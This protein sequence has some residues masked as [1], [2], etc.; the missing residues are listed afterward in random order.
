MRP[1][2]EPPLGRLPWALTATGGPC[3]ELS[4]F[5]IQG[6][7]PSALWA[8]LARVQ[9]LDLSNN[10]ISGTIPESIFEMRSLLKL[11]LENN[12]LSGNIPDGIEN[13]PALAY[14]YAANA[15]AGALAHI[16]Y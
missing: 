2:L 5:G 11:N 15:P 3:S 8:G 14:M 12:R 13:A 1:S 16:T 9:G 7:L 6:P 4:G 10:D